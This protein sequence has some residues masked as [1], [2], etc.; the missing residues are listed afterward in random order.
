MSSDHTWY[1]VIVKNENN[2]DILKFEKLEKRID[3]LEKDNKQLRD[4]L[5]EIVTEN[6]KIRN[7]MLE[8]EIS[9]ERTKNMLL[10]NHIPFSFSSTSVFK[11]PL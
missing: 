11:K 7:K 6:L 1:D 8:T 10:R 4:E 3:D 2:P 9:L 5:K